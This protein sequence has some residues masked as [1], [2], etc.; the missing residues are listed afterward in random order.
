MLKTEI[1]VK[2]IVKSVIR[3]AG[4]DLA[5]LQSS[6]SL[7]DQNP[8]VSEREWA[9]WSKVSPFSML[10]LER[11]LANIR[12]VDHVVSRGIPGDI[13]ECGV[14]RGGSSMAMALALEKQPSRE[15]WLYDTYAGMTEAT[16]ADLSNSGV[17]AAQLLKD[18][19]EHE[20]AERS[21]VIAYASL[22]DV[23]RNVQSTGY[24]ME[25]IRFI[26]G[27]VE[28]TLPAQ[29]PEQICLLRID[30]DWYEST[31]HELIHLYPRLSPGGILIIDDYGHWQGAR[32]AVDEYFDGRGP[33]LNRIDYTGRMA[34]KP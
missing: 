25:S 29:M 26:Q 31:R 3:R 4:Y 21:L 19:R 17:S 24:P 16:D 32:K 7:K 14:W 8:D 23:R 30:T 5:P 2:R 15:L 6:R 12:A 27:P 28:K 20:V 10:S 11:I 1:Q 34:V 22:D 33:F 9:I 13:V 18:A